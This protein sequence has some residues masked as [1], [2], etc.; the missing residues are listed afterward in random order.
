MRRT[1]TPLPLL[2]LAACGGGGDDDIPDPTQPQNDK[3]ITINELMADNALSVPDAGDWI[4][5]HNAGPDDVNLRGYTVTD[6]LTAAGAVIPDDRVVPAGGW[7]VIDLQGIDV[8][9]PREGG[10]VGLARPDGSWVDRLT[11]DEQEVDF[12]AAREPDGSDAWVVEWHVSPGAANPDGDGA[13]VGEEN[14][15]D[16][17][18][19]IPAAGDLSERILGYDVMPELELQISDAGVASLL[20]DPR[21][22]VEATIVFDGRSY[23]PV[24]LRLK[25]NKSFLPFDQK[26]SLRINVDQFVTGAKFFGLDDLTLDNMS[27]D[28]SMLH[29]RMSYWIARQA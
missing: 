16:P 23:G 9:L 14:A 10:Q 7:L 28:R 6:D 29:E 17:P 12:S 19:A 4:E 27:S 15:D 11:Y 22:Y 20:A 25:G 13:P 5:L 26:P 18:E 8:D 1:A 21:T 3:A 2:V 24:G